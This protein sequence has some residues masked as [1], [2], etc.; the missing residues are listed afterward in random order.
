[1]LLLF[2]FLLFFRKKITTNPSCSKLCLLQGFC[3]RL[4][5]VLGC[6]CPFGFVAVVVL[7]RKGFRGGLFLYL[8]F[9][10]TEHVHVVLFL[11]PLAHRHGRFHQQ[12]QAFELILVVADDA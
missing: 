12:V 5:R 3:L 4:C 9:L 11:F 1:M 8:S 10:I 2:R 6:R 7:R